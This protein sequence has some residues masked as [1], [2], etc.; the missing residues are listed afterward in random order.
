M[1]GERRSTGRQAA[2]PNRYR[3]RSSDP[4]RLVVID[5]L[6]PEGVGPPT[7][8]DHHSPTRLAASP[9]AGIYTQTTPQ[10]TVSVVFVGFAD[11]IPRMRSLT[12]ELAQEGQRDELLTTGEAAKLLNVSRQHIVDL[13]TNGDLPFSTV[14]THRRVRRADLVQLRSRTER[15][16]R[17]QER[18]LWLGHA[19]AGKLVADPTGVLERAQA[20]L[21]QLQARHPRGQAARWLDEWGRLLSGPTAAVLDALT[22]RSLRA[23]EL[24]QNS[25]FAGVLSDE[26]RH[27]VLAAFGES[28]GRPRR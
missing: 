11:I 23:R 20:N 1:G 14:G 5:V 21:A 26:E 6:P 24:R 7:G 17:D 13:C 9:S 3:R 19:I 28:Q 15:L 10:A 4:E 18:S 22:S 16:T 2:S 27:Q 12:Y 25:P 8:P